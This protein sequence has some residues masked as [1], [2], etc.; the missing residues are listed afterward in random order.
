[1]IAGMRREQQ[2]LSSNPVV[3]T[4]VMKQVENPSVPVAK[5]SDENK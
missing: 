2:A 1:M 4:P 5:P 3:F